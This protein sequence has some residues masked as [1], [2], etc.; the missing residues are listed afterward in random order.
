[1]APGAALT[2]LGSIERRSGAFAYRVTKLLSNVEIERIR[3]KLQ[4]ALGRDLTPE[5]SRYLGLSTVVLTDGE[6]VPKAKAATNRRK[7]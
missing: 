5:E 7:D 3:S 4:A 1:M 2:D 6:P